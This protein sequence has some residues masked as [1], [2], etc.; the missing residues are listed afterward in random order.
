MHYKLFI[1]RIGLISL[2][3]II[4]SFRNILLMPILTKSLGA[5]NYGIW[6]QI[7]VTVSLLSLI[8]VLGLTQ[9]E[10]RF[11][12]GLKNIDDLQEGLYSI[13]IL[14]IASSIG[15]SICLFMLSEFLARE[16]LNEIQFKY[17]IIL[18]GPIVLFSAVNSIMLAFLTAR[19]RFKEYTVLNL[20]LKIFELIFP[21]AA[22]LVGYSISGVIFSLVILNFLFFIIITSYT[23]FSIGIKVPKFINMRM[24]LGFSLPLIPT[25]IFIWII[26]GSDRYIIGYFLGTTPVG[27]YSVAYGIASILQLAFS[28]IGLVLFP[29]IAQLWEEKK[30]S[31][32]E[33]FLNFSLRYYLMIAIPSIFG[34]LILSKDF[35]L[36]LSTPEFISGS[37]LIPIIAMG[38]VFYQLYSIY[39]YVLYSINKT[40]VIAVVMFLAAIFNII[41]TIVLVKISGLIGAAISSMITYLLIGGLIIYMVHKIIK[42]NID[43]KFLL[44]CVYS[45]TIM[46]VAVLYLELHDNSVIGIVINIIISALFYFVILYLIGGVTN[47]EI[48]FIKNCFSNK[49]K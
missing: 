16:L 43:F 1:Q 14:V 49:Y 7:T 17:L 8:A 28:P 26:H 32:A 2:L 31:E 5:F 35:I 3:N 12:S 20:I 13:I 47:K 38:F 23:V 42:I 24:Y 44:R 37:G 33:N 39:H 34:L 45:S 4:I 19:M 22:I 27:I 25:L 40:A 29:T 30:I 36:I 18:I 48:N 21:F 9:A 46:G 6:S 11:L 41:I 15:L 10:V